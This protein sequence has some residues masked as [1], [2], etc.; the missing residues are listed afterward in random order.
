MRPLILATLIALPQPVLADK[1]ATGD[2]WHRH[3]LFGQVIRFAPVIAGSAGRAPDHAAQQGGNALIEYIPTGESLQGW[4]EMHTLTAAQGLGAANPDATSHARA[5]GAH[6]RQGYQGACALDVTEVALAAPPVEGARA[7]WAGFLGC[8]HVTG[9][10][11]G[12]SMVLFVII[13]QRDTFTLQWAQRGLARSSP[14]TVDPAELQRR[15]DQLAQ[16]RLCL[17]SPGEAPPYPSCA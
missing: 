8:D 16:V 12:E 14:Q 2:P 9:T 4:S 6:F 10:G 13:G 7:T 17:P 11:R 5:I 15:L 3:A 1:P